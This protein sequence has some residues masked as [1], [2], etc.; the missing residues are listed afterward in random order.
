MAIP[1]VY[2]FLHREIRGVHE[3]AYLLAFFTLGSQLMGLVRD[4]LLAGSFGTGEVLDVFYAAFRIPDT[5]Y[6]LLASMVSLFV[7]IPFLEASRKQGKEA[8]RDFLSDMLSFFSAMLIALGFLVFIFAPQLV[9]LLYAGFST[10]MQ[11]ELV[12]MVRILLIQPFVLGI[13]N[14]FAAY[15]QVKGRFLLYAVAPILYNIGI[16]IG[17]LWFEPVLGI[18]GLAWGVVLGAVLH[19]LIQAPFVIHQGV[20]PRFQMPDMHRVYDV[21]RLSIPRTIT[22]SAQQVVLLVLVSM[23]SLFAV[24][25]VSSFSFAWNLQ[26]VPLAI[27]GASYSVAA[28]PKL[29]MLFGSGERARYRALIITATRHILF[30]AIPVTILVI[31]LRAQLVRVIFGTGAFD[32]AATMLVGALLAMFVISLSAQ[33]LVILLVRACYAAGKTFVPLVLNV[34]SSIATV[35]LAGL[36]IVYEQTGALDIEFLARLMRVDG[37]AGNEV[38]LI[39]LAYSVGSILNALLLLAYFELSYGHVF[40]DIARTVWQAV[41]AGLVGGLAAYGALNVLDDFLDLATFHGIFLQGLGAGVVGILAWVSALIVLDSN[42][43]EVTWGT[44]RRRLKKPSVEGV[45]GDVGGSS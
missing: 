21:V 1:L 7:L 23:A 9:Q 14:L 29:A 36:L 24:G 19:L 26:A 15:V 31:V 28:F 4:R 43:L 12:L 22:L 41:T 44:L 34:G 2:R 5:M 45:Q 37:V 11:E 18:A 16:I 35:L 32:W 8:V 6:A 10:P 27:I 25:S 39:V 38:L 17:V 42:D 33:G 3:A 30:W 20:A 40:R 13:S